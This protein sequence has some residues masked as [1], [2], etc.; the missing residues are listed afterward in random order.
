LFLAFPQEFFILSLVTLLVHQ[1]NERKRMQALLRELETAHRQLEQYAAQTAGLTRAAERQRMARDLHDTLAQG[2]AGLILQL[3]AIDARLS[4]GGSAQAQII[5]HQA[6][7]RARATLADARRAI[8]D[9]RTSESSGA[10]EKSGD[11]LCAAIQNEIARFTTTSGVW[12]EVECG[13]PARLPAALYDPVLRTVSE[14][15]SNIARHAYA[16]RAWVRLTA[17]SDRLHITIRDDGI[18]FDPATAIGRNGHYG[19]TGLDERAQLAGGEF[20]VTSAPGGGA[21][22]TLQ[23]PLSEVQ[24]FLARTQHA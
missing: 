18:G 11:A 4:R 19:L 24:P 21:T 17:E 12:C 13:L 14:S 20:L 10:N 22:I 16:Q 3:E 1:S 9:L 6:M 7:S 2:L 23:L 15:L 5:V 8:D